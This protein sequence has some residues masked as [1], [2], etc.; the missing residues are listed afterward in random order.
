MRILEVIP[1]ERWRHISGRTASM[2]GACPWTTDAERGEWTCE[3]IGWTW[4]RADGCI[5]LGRV[6]A[7]TREEALTVMEKIN[8]RKA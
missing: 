1:A 8:S 4:Q 3:P 2:Y 7:K 6:P 5:G